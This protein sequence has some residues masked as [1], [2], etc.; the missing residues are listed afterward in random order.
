MSPLALIGAPVGALAALFTRTRNTDEQAKADE[1][2][3]KNLLI[4]GLAAYNS[5]KRVGYSIRNPD[6]IKA[7]GQRKIDK[8]KT[9]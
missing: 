1:N 3:W 5:W 7:Q 2:T 6:L 4:P 8:V 9:E